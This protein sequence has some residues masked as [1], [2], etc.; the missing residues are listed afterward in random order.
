MDTRTTSHEDYN[1][2][3]ICAL[4]KEQTAAT[5]M[6]DRIHPN[7]PKPASDE[8]AYTL[9]SIGGHKI[10]IACLPKGTVGTNEAA[11]VAAQ[12]LS[13]F[14][15]IKIGLMVGIGGGIPPKV[16]LGD[17]VVG[18]Q[19]IQWDFG[20]AEGIFKRT[21][22]RER[23]PRALRTAISKL[24]TEHDLREAKIPQYL[25]DL[26]V[27][28][29]KM[30]AKYGWSKSL[31][32]P[33]FTPDNS[34]G[35]QGSAASAGI[36]GHQRKPGDV[37]IHYAAAYAKE[38]LEYIGP[39]D[40]D[41]ERPIKEMLSKVCDDIAAVRFKLAG[42]ED[43]EILNW[44]TPIDYSPQQSDYLGRRQPG[45]GK[46]FLASDEYK[47][48]LEYKHVLF[49]PGIPGAGKTILTSI[50][51]ND[52][53]TRFN[54][55]LTVGIAYI[56]CNFKRGYEQQLD[57][58]LASLLKQ[59]AAQCQHSLPSSI[60]E[61]HTKLRRTRPSHEDI[62]KILRS[63]IKTYY[64]RVFIVIDALDEYPISNGRMK[65]LSELFRLYDKYGANIFATSRLIP[66]ITETFK[67]STTLE[68]RAHDEDVR[69]YLNEQIS[70]TGDDLLEN[71]REHIKTGIANAARGM[72]LLATY[73]FQW[74]KDSP[75]AKRLKEVLKTLPTGEEGYDHTY[76]NT[77]ERIKIY[78]SGSRNL[79]HQV[80]LW[81]TC[82][83]RLLTPLELQ[84]AIAI[85]VGENKL[86]ED[87]LPDV[88][89]MVSL[90]TGLVMVDEKSNVIRL[91]HYTTQ[92][93]FQRTWKKWFPKAQI[94]IAKRCVTYLSYDI[95][96]KVPSL[97][98]DSIQTMLKSNA[99][100]IY[101]AQNWGH[102]V[103]G[104]TIETAPLVLGLLGDKIGL[105]AC[106]R[107]M[108]LDRD[109]FSLSCRG[110]IGVHFAAYFGLWESMTVM[111]AEGADIEAK[112]EEGGTP[113]LWAALNGHKAVVRLLVDNGADLE[114]KDGI[115]E[116]T[117]LCWAALNGHDAVV[118]LLID[119]GADLGAK[120][121]FCNDTPLHLAASGGHEAVV[122]LL[123]DNGADLEIK[124]GSGETP[125]HLAASG[126][127]EAVVRPLVENGA[128]LEVKGSG[129]TPLHL[130]ASG[131]HEAVVRL[132]VDK[133]A[134][135][136]A[137][138]HIYESTPLHQAASRGHEAVVKLLVDR[139]ASLEV[140][141]GYGATPLC[142]A[143][144]E[145]HE[146]VVRML[147]DKIADL[148][149]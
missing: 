96:K 64:S 105:S 149:A 43:T 113:L 24:E 12:M 14:P 79:V 17:V 54:G 82:A 115:N 131:G 89:K 143:M 30:V 127:H 70:Q 142:Q 31:K 136:K 75:T 132:L 90:C 76:E 44:I 137:T 35:S 111:V 50:V 5:A 53:I 63:I 29:P 58:L 134:D 61:L 18:T 124:N 37:Y 138:D 28:Y 33:L 118:K 26:K 55:D 91:T 119:E 45:T 6:L 94:D 2:G 101:A 40:V 100:Y 130:A 122:R 144:L 84:H 135:L 78:N 38:L 22:T 97:T 32:D 71:Y 27:K 99:L 16:R 47:A 62:V 4:P 10:V 133:G 87:N 74:V 56:Y 109:F 67:S 148:A 19:V 129:E 20:K 42:K 86:D 23:P 57:D 80:L 60:K 146:A 81:I 49:C 140:K 128:G 85:E 34:D 25:N 13:T 141:D 1:V 95:F 72:F 107:V 73:H 83:K 93:Y 66:Q 92:E 110:M 51:V 112:D 120:D 65:F 126:G 7:L 145:G 106:S 117:P 121:H 48:W 77:M 103:R 46:W 9:G 41:E 68:I 125:L 39:G 36:S 59:L 52:L 108:S 88:K 21:S 104:S 114:A 139:G 3:W 147:V 98:D 102:H 69:N 8:N 15:S 123:V 116:R 11:I